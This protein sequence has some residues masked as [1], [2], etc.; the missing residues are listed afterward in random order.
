M[1]AYDFKCPEGHITEHFMSYSRLQE[2][3]EKVECGHVDE[4][5][6]VCTLEGEYSPS[7]WYNSSTH[8][9][10]RFPPI[11]IHR[12]LEGNVRFPAHADAP[13]PPGFQRVEL[14]DFHQVRKFENEINLRDR[15]RAEEFRNSRQKFLDGQ[16]KENRRVMEQLVEK[17][18]PRGRRFY[19][20]MRKVSEARQQR[21]V[22]APTPEFYIEALT[23]DASNRERYMDAA[24]DWGKMQGNRK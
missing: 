13:L 6:K 20:A 24:N 9:A 7:F 10:Q 17:F 8:F 1:A 23:Q 4:D 11:V 15:A 21:G 5:G 12:D 18:T 22:K 14:T 19:D 3:G 2:L 16:L